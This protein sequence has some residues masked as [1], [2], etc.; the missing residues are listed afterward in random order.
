MHFDLFFYVE[1]ESGIKN[2]LS[3]KTEALERY[4][5]SKIVKNAVFGQFMGSMTS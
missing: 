5:D 2:V 3:T 4:K 1:S